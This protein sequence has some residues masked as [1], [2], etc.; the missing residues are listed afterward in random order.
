MKYII[1]VLAF[2]AMSCN[3]KAEDAHAHNEDGSHVG[4]EI[5][6]LSHTLWTDKTESFVEFP[7]LIVGNPSKFAAHFTILDKHQPIK[8][9]SVTVSLIKGD[10]GIRNTAEAPSSPGIFSRMT[11]T[12]LCSI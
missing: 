11:H 12:K 2:L 8:D 9:G 1:V 4:E 3:N 10:N 6:R 5:Q 7:A